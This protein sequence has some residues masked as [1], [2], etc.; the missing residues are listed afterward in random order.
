M[1]RFATRVSAGLITCAAAAEVSPAA[2][3]WAFFNGSGEQI[4][5][6]SFVEADAGQWVGS[7]FTP[8]EFFDTTALW[9]DA[10]PEGWLEGT[11]ETVTLTAQVTFRRLAND[12]DFGVGLS[13]GVTHVTV[14][15]RENDNGQIVLYSGAFADDFNRAQRGTPLPTLAIGSGAGYPERLETATLHATFEFGPAGVL[16]SGRIDNGPTFTAPSPVPLDAAQGWDLFL[17][18]EQDRESYEFLNL[19]YSVDPA[20]TSV[21]TEFWDAGESIA[22]AQPAYAKADGSPVYALSGELAPGD[23]ADVYSVVWP[24]SASFFRDRDSRMVITTQGNEQ[25][26]F[27]FAD[28]DGFISADA[29]LLPGP[30]A[31]ESVQEPAVSESNKVLLIIFRTSSLALDPSGETLDLIGDPFGDGPI[32]RFEAT[33]AHEI[34]VAYDIRFSDLLPAFADGPWQAQT[35]AFQEVDFIGTTNAEISVFPSSESWSIV[36]TGGNTTSDAGGW[37]PSFQDAVQLNLST[38]ALPSGIY[39][40][41]GGDTSGGLVLRVRDRTVA[42]VEEDLFLE[43]SVDQSTQGGRFRVLTGQNVFGG[44][45][46]GEGEFS[47]PATGDFVFYTFDI[48]MDSTAQ[49]ELTV[50]FEQPFEF[51]TDTNSGFDSIIEDGDS[52]RS[53]VFDGSTG[54][55]FLALLPGETLALSGDFNTDGD[56]EGVFIADWRP[57]RVIDPTCPLDT[58]RNEVLDI[59]DI[60][61]FLGLFDAL[62][63]AADVAEPAGVFDVFDVI[64]F[65]ALFEDGCD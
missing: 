64:E 44:F 4:E 13:D 46:S 14:G 50:A 32:D 31:S 55:E 47:D 60:I 21:H 12:C 10:L 59:F 58:D 37:T 17:F 28:A 30:G 38:L 27:I 16:I 36:Q 49:A 34:P 35:P 8:I 48:F 62:D 39:T 41:V 3:P 7:T 22:D 56:P 23:V 26:A 65:L 29:S 63:P 9:R 11:P 25:I 24:R 5:S 33:S 15:G 43:A 18:G 53:S 51:F 52:S 20:P 1:Q 57:L 42:E 19:T 6:L 2:D 40:D 45:A 61:A 54:L